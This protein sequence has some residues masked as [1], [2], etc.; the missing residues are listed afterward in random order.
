MNEFLNA[1]GSDE[2]LQVVIRGMVAGASEVR[3]LNQPYALV[4]RDPRADIPLDH[5]LVSRRHVYIQIIGGE[6]FWLDLDSRSGT[7]CDGQVRDSGWLDHGK[8]IRVGPFGL[9]RQQRNGPNREAQGETRISPLIARSLGDHPLPEIALEFL[10]GPSR[11]ACWPMNRVMSLVGS[12][13][14]CKFRLDDP[15]VAPFHCCLVR[16]PQGLWAVDLLGHDGIGVNDAIPRCALLAHD[17]VLRIGRYRIRI[18]SRFIG[19][20]L[21]RTV[22]SGG[23]RST[24]NL[25]PSQAPGSLQPGFPSEVSAVFSHPSF[26][27]IAGS[28]TRLTPAGQLTGLDL[29]TAENEAVVVERGN[30]S[31]S[32]VVSLVNQFSLMQQQMLDQFQQTISILVQTFGNLHRE[33]MDTIREELD[34]IR[35]LGKEFQALKLELAARSQDRVAGAPI[36]SGAV[37]R[38]EPVPGRRSGQASKAQTRIDGSAGSSAALEHSNSSLPRAPAGSSQSS[39]S[40]DEVSSPLASNSGSSGQ[41][42]SAG[43]YRPESDRDMVVWLHQRMVQLQQERE[44]R[45]QKILKLLPGLS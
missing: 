30:L 24:K 28:L 19:S 22:A 20:E 25:M 8:V 13:S 39:R 18:R 42:V 27:P 4:G 5:T 2:P 33:Q 37:A 35:D 7:F 17:D 12:S 44:T 34:Q 40:R 41:R 11:S 29:I 6:A 10:N 21:A 23:K 32:L 15:S 14:G 16:T 9:E 31:E 36:I 43:D 26:A 45:W 3:L 1:C 38:G